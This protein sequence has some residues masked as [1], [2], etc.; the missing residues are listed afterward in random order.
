VADSG[1]GV[2]GELKEKI[3]EP[4]GTTKPLGMGMGLSIS[5]SIVEAHEGRLR[6]AQSAGS[7]AVFA[8]DLPADGSAATSHAG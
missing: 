5:R 8:F 1:P 4:F 7:G 2:V 3:F 6:M